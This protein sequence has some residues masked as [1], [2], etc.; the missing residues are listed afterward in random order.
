MT[1]K[2]E[3]R[4]TPFFGNNTKGLKKIIVV[5]SQLPHQEFE[6]LQS[7]VDSHRFELHE[8]VVRIL[9]SLA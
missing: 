2:F 9:I 4:V 7:V 3:K 5:W 8:L 6:A 1:Q